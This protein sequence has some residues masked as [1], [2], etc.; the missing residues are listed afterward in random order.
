MF[1]WFICN[2]SGL[3]QQIGGVKSRRQ[4]PL[5]PLINGVC[6]LS[7]LLLAPSQGLCVVNKVLLFKRVPAWQFSFS[8]E[9]ESPGPGA[10]NGPMWE[11]CHRMLVMFWRLLGDQPLAV[12]GGGVRGMAGRLWARRYLKHQRIGGSG[13]L[14]P[15][16][17]SRISTAE[18]A[19]VPATDGWSGGDADVFCRSGPQIPFPVTCCLF[20]LSLNCWSMT[21]ADLGVKGV[22]DPQGDTLSCTTIVYFR[23]WPLEVLEST[24]AA[25]RRRAYTRRG[26]KAPDVWFYHFIDICGAQNSSWDEI[27]FVL[28]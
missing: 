15:R 23:F 19:G 24:P 4:T 22:R 5:R 18:A 28:S 1:D 10:G 20:T 12:G 26:Q 17:G 8:C 7:A 6:R 21:G 25:T 2:G 14:G 11:K 16:V 3:R 27:C 9:M 13:T